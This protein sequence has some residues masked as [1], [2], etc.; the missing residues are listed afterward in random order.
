MKSEIF[1]LSNI[2]LFTALLLIKFLVII[3]LRYQTFKHIR[4]ILRS[5]YLFRRKKN[6]FEIR[7]TCDLW[8]F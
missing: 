4:E 5:I 3:Y 7:K 1:F 8:L 6:N 2:F